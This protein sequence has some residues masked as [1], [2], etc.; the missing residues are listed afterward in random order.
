[1]AV[2]GDTYISAL[3]GEAGGINVFAEGEKRYP[4]VTLDHLREAGPDVVLL[5][6]EPYPFAP[7]HA[8]ELEELA[9]RC[10]FVDGELL[11]W[12]G[13]R[14]AAAFPYLRDFLAQGLPA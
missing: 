2:S 8:S 4:A 11:C 10:C 9:E 7:E 13:T 12:H 14:M 1:M 3:L 5:P 6:S